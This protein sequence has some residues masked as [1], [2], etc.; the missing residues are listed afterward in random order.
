MERGRV[1]EPRGTLVVGLKMEQEPREPVVTES[2]AT[3][4]NR[5]FLSPGLRLSVYAEVS[6][7]L[8]AVAGCHPLHGLKI[9]RAF[10]HGINASHSNFPQSLGHM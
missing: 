5:G 10:T 2:N 3:H 1:S 6:P 8:A 7:G 9:R 4:Y